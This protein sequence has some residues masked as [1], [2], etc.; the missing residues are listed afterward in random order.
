MTQ[1]NQG[2]PAPHQDPSLEIVIPRKVPLAILFA[3]VIQ[4]AGGIWAISGFYYSQK[5]MQNQMSE[6]ITRFTTKMNELKS[7]IYTRDEA[8]LQLQQRQ[9]QF[10]AN[11][12]EN[13]RQD[14]EI[15]EM[16]S[17][18]YGRGQ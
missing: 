9:L 7:T 18:L 15:Q 5:E 13:R 12:Q 8:L 1:N 14:Q 10:D 2:A 17:K 16:R 4:I 11:R 3:L 6:N